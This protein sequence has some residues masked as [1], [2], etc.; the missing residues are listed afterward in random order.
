MMLNW[1]YNEPW[2][3]AANNSIVSYPA[4][5]K[6]AYEFVKAALRPTLFSAR[7]PKFKWAEGEKFKAEIWLLNDTNEEVERTASVCLKIGDK[8]ISLLEKVSR[9][10]GAKE[11]V[12]CAAV[13]TVL[14]EVGDTEDM[15]LLIA[16]DGD[17]SNE[18]R[19]R[20]EPRKKIAKQKMLN[21]D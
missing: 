19:L 21:K 9:K 10:A 7:I 17:A 12:E 5:P 16:G 1:C 11:N 14:P 6:P 18:Y 20:Y 15:Y 2:I 3:T 4:L 8:T 13:C